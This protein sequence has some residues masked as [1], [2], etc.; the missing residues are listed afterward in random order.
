MSLHCT[1]LLVSVGWHYFRIVSRISLTSPHSLD[2]DEL[3]WVKLPCSIS[4][5]CFHSGLD[6]LTS[7]ESC[8]SCLSY[9][10]LLPFQAEIHRKDRKNA[11]DISKVLAYLLLQFQNRNQWS[12]ACQ[13]CFDWSLLSLSVSRWN[14]V[15]PLAFV[16]RCHRCNQSLHRLYRF[17]LL[18][19]SNYHLVKHSVTLGQSQEQA[20][21]AM[22]NFR[23]HVR[24]YEVLSD[25]L[26]LYSS[27]QYSDL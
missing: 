19:D 21:I 14:L 5:Y 12:F 16:F 3:D 1:D 13:W 2:L 9:H 18:A 20:I 17:V 7:Y 25:S 10:L 6:P 24:Y 23:S 22:T 15:L 26:R 27:T 8:Q 11:V 4:Q